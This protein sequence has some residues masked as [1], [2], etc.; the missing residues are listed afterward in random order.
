MNINSNKRGQITLFIILAIIIVAGVIILFLFLNKSTDFFQGTPKIDPEQFP[1]KCARDAVSASIDKILLGGGRIN[2]EKTIL[3][4]N[5]E[6][7]Y[8]CYQ[9]MDLTPCINHYPMIKS[10]VE[11]EIKQ[12]TEAAVRACF[13]TLEQEL[14]DKGYTVSS[15]FLDYNIELQPDLVSIKIN[16]NLEYNKGTES[17]SFDDFNTAVNSPLYD[18]LVVVRRII[19]D[20]AEDLYFEYD[21]YMLMYPGFNILRVSFDGSRIYRV[22]DRQ[23]GKE[24]KFAIKGYLIPGRY[25]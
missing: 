13:I 4:N 1:Q 17:Y 20:E 5:E 22:I 15:N 18:L 10:I 11:K 3:F 7:N 25:L 21:K 19:N 8:L 12:D 23:S 14:E 24:F 6:F 2:P 16:A 9:D